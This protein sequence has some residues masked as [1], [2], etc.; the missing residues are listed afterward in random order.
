MRE[1]DFFQTDI[2]KH[3]IR[4]EHDSTDGADREERA[5]LEGGAV[6]VGPQHSFLSDFLPEEFVPYVAFFSS[7]FSA[8]SECLL[9]LL[10]KTR[11]FNLLCSQIAVC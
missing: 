9:G 7:R 10:T 2:L 1:N 4:N 5:E 11:I 6:L 8:L 3:Q